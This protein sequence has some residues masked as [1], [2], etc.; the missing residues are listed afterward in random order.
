MVIALA[1]LLIFVEGA[2]SAVRAR[3]IVIV[4]LGGLLRLVGLAEQEV[5]PTAQVHIAGFA[6]QVSEVFQWR[7]VQRLLLAKED[8]VL[9]VNHLVAHFTA[10]LRES[11]LLCVHALARF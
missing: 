1:L 9:L 7:L 6:A 5:A 2:D 11:R 8:C 3:A 4:V 10:V